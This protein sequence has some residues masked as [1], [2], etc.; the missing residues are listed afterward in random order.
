MIFYFEEF[1][2]FLPSGTSIW[3]QGWQE[4]VT[5]ADKKKN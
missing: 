3:T 5:T 2:F 1:V 4:P